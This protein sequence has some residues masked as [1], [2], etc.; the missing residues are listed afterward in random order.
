M[1][2]SKTTVKRTVFNAVQAELDSGRLTVEQLLAE[3]YGQCQDF[4]LFITNLCSYIGTS[5]GAVRPETV[6]V[7]IREFKRIKRNELKSQNV[8][9]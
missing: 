1:K 6:Q 8:T 9:V 5:W 2:L 4:G 7:Y 3:H